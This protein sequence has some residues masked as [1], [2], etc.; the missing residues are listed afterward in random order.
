MKD[1]KNMKKIECLVSQEKAVEIDEVCDKEG[2]TRAEF[3][4]RAIDHY[5]INKK[6]AAEI[7]DAIRNATINVLIESAN[8]K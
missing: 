4:R 8:K 6:S 1:K 5:L 7:G 2:Y 3:T